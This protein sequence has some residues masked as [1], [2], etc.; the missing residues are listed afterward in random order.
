MLPRALQRAQCQAYSTVYKLSRAIVPSSHLLC[1]RRRRNEVH[2]AIHCCH[3]T[4]HICLSSY[5]QQATTLNTLSYRAL[6]SSASTRRVPS[7]LNQPR[8]RRTPRSGPTPLT[9]TVVGGRLY[10]LWDLVRVL[11]LHDVECEKHKIEH[12]K[13]VQEVQAKYDLGEA[14][15]RRMAGLDPP[16]F[17]PFKDTMRA[18]LRNTPRLGKQDRQVICDLAYDLQKYR[19]LCDHISVRQRSHRS[20]EKD[21]LSP[22]PSSLRELFDTDHI[23]SVS[24]TEQALMLEWLRRLHFIVQFEKEALEKDARLIVHGSDPPIEITSAVPRAA[25]YSFD[26]QLAEKLGQLQNSDALMSTLNTEAPVS[27]RINT[28]AAQQND[29]NIT[30]EQ[31]ISQ[32]QDDPYNIPASNVRPSTLC[33]NGIVLA[34]TSSTRFAIDS[35][36]LFQNGTIEVQDES[37]QHIASLI[38]P[39]V[40]DTILDFCCGAGG[41]ALPIAERIASLGSFEET[42]TRLF[43]HDVR[44]SAMNELVRR[45]ERAHL[46]TPFAANSFGKAKPILSQ[47]D[48]CISAASQYDAHGALDHQFV[49]VLSHP[50]QGFHRPVTARGA[51]LSQDR[52]RSPLAH[53]F[54][55]IGL[56]ADWVLVDAPCSGTGRLRRERDIKNVFSS[57]WL[58]VLKRTQ[59][60][61]VYQSL[62]YLKPITGR[63][64]YSTCSILPEENMEQVDRLVRMCG[65]RVDPEYP[66]IELQPMLDGHDG[67]FAVV[68]LLEDTSSIPTLERMDTFMFD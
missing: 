57:E 33:D 24:R 40:G 16:G 45:F 23:R 12:T 58:R 9:L 36:P 56:Q 32:L 39:K 52:L 55:E 2:G 41:K 1:R 34:R 18:F 65:L 49:T 4:T 59:L 5:K 27:L 10:R 43:C 66:V 28:I 37:T 30:R 29:R 60:Y 50:V 7:Q 54:D 11:A 17:V 63:L 53:L 13:R 31:I 64:V 20:A 19:I 3:A 14:Q 6:S 44:P 26:P 61:L 47:S 62:Q 51:D 48:E 38:K 15:A 25:R 46:D 35:W 22:A 8:R 67:G 42:D 21:G 68:L